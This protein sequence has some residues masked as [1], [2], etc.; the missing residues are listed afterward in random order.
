MLD[1]YRQHTEE[2]ASLGLPP[3]PLNV[4][5]VAA[6]LERLKQ[7]EKS[8]EGETLLNLLTHRVPPGVDEAAYVKAGFLADIA[9]GNTACSMITPTQATLLLGTMLGGYNLQPLIDLLDEDE[10]APT[11]AKGLSRDYNTEVIP[12]S[13]N[14]REL[15]QVESLY[16]QVLERFGKV[17]FLVNNGGGQFL[18]HAKNISEKGWKSVI[19]TN[20]NGT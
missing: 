4:E 18:A 6:L 11:A 19:D 9:K 13:C 14:I 8:D 7:L 5:Q 16:D 20:L 15:E 1:A 3:L 2:R 17:D 12:V 10:L